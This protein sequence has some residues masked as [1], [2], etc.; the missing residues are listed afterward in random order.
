MKEPCHSAAQTRKI[1]GGWGKC[2][3]LLLPL[4]VDSLTDKKPVANP[5]KTATRFLAMAVA[6]VLCVMAQGCSS[7]KH[8]AQ[9][10]YLLD[11]VDIAVVD[12][13]G[14]STKGLV[15]YL[16][17]SPNHKVLGF[18]KLQLGVYNLSGKS[19]SKFNR[20]LRK[21]GQE[22]VIYDPQLTDQSARQLRLALVNRGYNDVE[23][24]VDTVSDG[25]KKMAVSY[26]SLIHI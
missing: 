12:S 14:V 26:L 18:W 15:N 23:V 20:W 7:T 22:P 8:V 24:E 3:E 25:K 9:G 11:K 2:G 13:S 21:I 4:Q 17:Q 19:D 1:G 16:R 5:A 10:S 6:A